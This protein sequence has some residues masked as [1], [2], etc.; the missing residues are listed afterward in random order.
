MM[1]H[2]R[3]PTLPRKFPRMGVTFATSCNYRRMPSPRPP[4]SDDYADP[5][6]LFKVPELPARNGSPA[7]PTS[8][9]SHSPFNDTFCEQNVTIREVTSRASSV[10]RK[11][12]VSMQS[13]E[14]QVA[15]YLKAESDFRSYLV[16]KCEF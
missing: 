3:F 13:Q 12:P 15:Y 6:E 4:G 16:Q 5:D 7:R 8:S 14:S 2:K 1:M 9:Q 10:T 11:R